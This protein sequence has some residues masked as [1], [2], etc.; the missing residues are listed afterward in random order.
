MNFCSVG[1]AEARPN[2]VQ[3]LFLVALNLPHC[4]IGIEY[5]TTY[6][7]KN[8]VLHNSD[9]A[10]N[11]SRRDLVPIVTTSLLLLVIVNI[12]SYP[13]LTIRQ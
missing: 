4:T 13:N 3:H 5:G 6:I 11:V 2:D 9:T 1:F 10:T 8:L 12:C 7:G